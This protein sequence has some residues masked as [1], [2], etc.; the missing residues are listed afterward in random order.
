MTKSFPNLHNEVK[1]YWLLTFFIL[2]IGFISSVE[3]QTVTPWITSGDQSKL[4]QQ[5]ANISFGSS[6]APNE[7]TIVI[8]PAT[9]YQVMDGFGYTLTEGSCELISAMSVTQQNA[10]LNDLYGPNG[11]STNIVRISIAASDLSSSSYSYNETVGDTNMTNFSLAGPD[12]TYLLPV[13]K[14]ILIINPAIKILATPWSSPRWMKTNNSWIGGSLK[15][16]YYNAYARYFVKYFDAMKAQGISIWGI[17]PQNE[18]ENANNEPSLLMNAT[19]QK[20]FINQHLGPQ[21][22]AAG[23]GGIKIIAFDHNCDNPNYAIDVANNSTYV[24]GSA[25]H[26]YLGDITA[27][28]K[29]H[30]ATNK[31][32]YFTEQYTAPGNFSGDFSWHMLNIVIGSSNN[33]AKT[34]LEWNVANNP[35]LGPRTPGGCTSCLGAVTIDGNNYS[36]NVAYYIIGQISKFVKPGALRVATST[37]NNNVA[38]AGFKNPDG[39]LIL[40]SLNQGT[41]SANVKIV[42]GSSAFNYTI[43]P[44]SAVTFS[45]ATNETVVPVTSISVTPT[46]ASIIVNNTTQL[47][48]TIAPANATNTNVNWDSSNTTVAIVNSSGLVTGIKP[49]TATITAKSQDG[50]KTAIANI[51][52]K[53][54]EPF[55]GTSASIPGIIQVENYDL[56][57]QN[58]AYNDSDATNNGNQYRKTESVDIDVIAGTSAYTLGWTVDGEWLEYTT[59]VI[60]GKYNIVAT[61]ASPNAGKKLVIKLDDV[62][63]TTLDIPNTGGYGS[64]KEVSIPNIIFTGGSN[65]ILRLEIVGGDFN[66]DKIAIQNTL[67]ISKNEFTDELLLHPNPVTS[68]LNINSKHVGD[69]SVSIYDITGSLVLKSAFKVEAIKSDITI[70]LTSLSKGLYVVKITNEKGIYIKKILKD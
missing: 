59:N 42:S 39:S 57:G 52:V 31:N 46:N 60:A 49:G 2:S 54:Q 13:L 28:S 5:Q 26:L 56:G 3:A 50:G 55:G 17:T 9:T 43:P 21:M 62:T 65:K 30:D 15:T 38:V 20:N 10:L 33:W 16:E 35:S 45:W 66:I 12:A 7:S 14:K 18:P 27:M 34:V 23:Y 4:L 47:T 11:I 8:N 19:E 25:F 1:K 37:T 48:A 58:V 53:N 68:Y 67:G 64:F 61:V 6:S 32:V 51:T 29:V 22:A 40:V 44:A 69:S 70:D 63:I 36:R 41:T 24:D